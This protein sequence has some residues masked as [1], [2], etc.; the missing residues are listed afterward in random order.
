MVI[1]QG[2]EER[3]KVGKGMEEN[4]KGPE[5]IVLETE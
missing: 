5:L 2:E 4:K 1:T 3:E